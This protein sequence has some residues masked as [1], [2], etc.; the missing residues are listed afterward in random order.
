MLG[1]QES[2]TRPQSHS[3]SEA[4]IYWVLILILQQVGLL[5]SLQTVIQTTSGN[6][7]AYEQKGAT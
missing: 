7:D 1:V 4:L 2:I 6:F 3:I 5:E